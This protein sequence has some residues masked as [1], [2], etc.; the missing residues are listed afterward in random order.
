MS[1]LCFGLGLQGALIPECEQ[2]Q[3]GPPEGCNS[4]PQKVESHPGL[5][6][7]KP[8]VNITLLGKTTSSHPSNYFYKFQE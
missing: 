1:L 2:E 4:Q 5:L 6:D 8:D 7:P 3:N